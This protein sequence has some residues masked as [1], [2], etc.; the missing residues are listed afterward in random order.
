M[1]PYRYIDMN[2]RYGSPKSFQGRYHDACDFRFHRMDDDLQP[3]IPA[4][5]LSGSVYYTKHDSTSPDGRVAF[6]NPAFGGN[7]AKMPG[8][9]RVTSG[10]SLVSA[11]ARV[12]NKKLSPGDSADVQTK[13]SNYNGDGDQSVFSN[14]IF[15]Q[16]MI[17]NEDSGVQIADLENSSQSVA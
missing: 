6:N 2:F 4:G 12:Q 5:G 8:D 16:P 11:I 13:A 3:V 1:L 9:D 10:L 14:P 7:D 17:Y 15:N